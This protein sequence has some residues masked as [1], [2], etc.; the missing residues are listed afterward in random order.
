MNTETI[1]I[2]APVITTNAAS[3]IDQ[4]ENLDKAIAIAKIITR[5]EIINAAIDS[6]G[7]IEKAYGSENTNKIL[8]IVVERAWREH[9]DTAKIILDSDIL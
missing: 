3:R 6:A 4:A 8:D 7:S 1:E 2:I 9:L 5:Q